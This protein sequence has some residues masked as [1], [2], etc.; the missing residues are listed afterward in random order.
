[1]AERGVFAVDRGLFEHPAF[2]AEPFTEREAWVWLISSAA[3]KDRTVRVGSRVVSLKR[4]QA[5]FSVRFLAERWQWSKSRVDRYLNRLE[6]Q[7]MIGT[8]AGT[9]VTVVTICNYDKYQRVSLPGRD[10]DGTETGTGAGQERDKEENKENKEEREEEE[11]SPP[12][13]PPPSSRMQRYA[14]EAGV[15][16]LNQKDFDLWKRA[17]EHLSLEAELISLVSWAETQPRWFHAVS[18]ALS[19]RNREIA[20]RKAQSAAQPPAPTFNAHGPEPPPRDPRTFTVS[21]WRNCLDGYRAHGH[22]PTSCWGPPPG[23]PGC[24]VPAE[25]LST[26]SAMI[27][28]PPEHRSNE[29][30]PH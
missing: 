10:S 20:I 3:W 8:E 15:I 22:W 12:A 18:G 24:Q 29:P 26:K 19:K 5:A 25:L 28:L 1:M 7:D 4:G 11:P 17:Y 2:A 6:N 27:T 23:E 14:F 16:R 30:K 21:D 9:G 13:P